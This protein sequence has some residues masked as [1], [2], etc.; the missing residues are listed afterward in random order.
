MLALGRMNPTAPAPQRNQHGYVAKRRAVIGSGQGCREIPVA[1]ARAAELP[2]LCP[3]SIETHRRGQ[4][5]RSKVIEWLR[6][7]RV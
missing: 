3:V 2:I 6:A 7:E 5:S 4:P 1:N